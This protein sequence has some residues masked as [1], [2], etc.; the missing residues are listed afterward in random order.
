MGELQGCC[1]SVTIAK[2][3]GMGHLNI[4][5]EKLD[6]VRRKELSNMIGVSRGGSPTVARQGIM[7]QRLRR[8]RIAEITSY[9]GYYD[10]DRS[11]IVT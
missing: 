9:R 11:I 4:S 6:D 1:V 7:K 10:L 3:V 2:S 8:R 5:L